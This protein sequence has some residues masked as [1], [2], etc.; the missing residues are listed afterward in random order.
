MPFKHADGADHKQR[1]QTSL[2]CD[3]ILNEDSLSFG[4]KINNLINT[5]LRN[6]KDFADASISISLARQKKAYY[7]TLKAIKSDDKE[8]IINCLLAKKTDELVNK[9]CNYEKG[10]S[11]T[12]RVNND[13]YYYFVG[14]ECEEDKYYGPKGNGTYIRAILEEYSQKSYCEREAIFFQDIIKEL[15][16]AM[17]HNNSFRVSLCL[18][19]GK[20]IKPFC[21]LMIKTDRIG[22][23]NYLV[24]ISELNSERKPASIRVSR[25]SKV[26]IMLS[27]PYYEYQK[28][29]DTAIVMAAL[30][31]QDVPYLLGEPETIKVVLNQDGLNKYN[32]IQ[33]K[34]PTTISEIETDGRTEKTFLCSQFQAEAYF[35]QFGENA[36]IKSPPELATKLAEFYQSA[37]VEYKRQL[38]D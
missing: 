13:M 36:I 29:E 22:M 14:P 7:E 21:P 32:Q 20:T 15:K 26:S 8:R 18:K 2:F 31:Q 25:I 10:I 16:K 1:F 24:G 23:Y 38:G 3:S 33:H 34:R 28:S 19:S 4:C 30:E 27:K 11:R 37:Y 17:T 9:H 35:N 5:I 6:Y 12:V